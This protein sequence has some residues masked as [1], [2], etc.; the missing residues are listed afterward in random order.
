MDHDT[1][2]PHNE[3]VSPAVPRESRPPVAPSPEHR[4]ESRVVCN[5][6]VRL[7]VGAQDIFVELM[8][9]SNNGF[10]VL[11]S[12]PELQPGRE[13]RF[14]HRF[15]VGQAEVVWT[16]LVAGRLQSGFRVVRT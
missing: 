10:R 5:G 2:G 1:F 3:S 16:Q 11:H 7:S 14:Q 13:V 15:F 4:H 6:Q 8:D 9:V 12:H